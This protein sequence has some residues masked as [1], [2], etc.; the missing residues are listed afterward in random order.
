MMW[1]WR[2]HVRPAI[3]RFRIVPDIG[4]ARNQER[5]SRARALTVLI[6]GMLPENDCAVESI[7][8]NWKDYLVAAH[9]CQIFRPQ[10]EFRRDQLASR[11]RRFGYPGAPVRSRFRKHVHYFVCQHSS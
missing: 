1:V 4:T 8:L 3:L 2:S 7:F 6:R 9:T 10:P 11:E 5:T